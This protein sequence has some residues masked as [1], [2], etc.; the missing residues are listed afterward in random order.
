MTATLFG[1]ETELRDRDDL[2]QGVI[3]VPN[4]GL[5]KIIVNAAVNHIW[6]QMESQ[7]RMMST[8]NVSSA[9]P[10]VFLSSRILCSFR[11]LYSLLKCFW[12]T[13]IVIK[14][15]THISIYF[16]PST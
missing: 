15:E 8:L 6:H 7:R 10:L 12:V 13:V 1:I 3:F 16:I 2:G 9:T 4:L 14:F 5:T 11:T